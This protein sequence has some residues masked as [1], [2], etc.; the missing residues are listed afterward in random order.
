VIVIILLTYDRLTVARTTLESV[1]AN[2]RA[3]EPFWLH[4][5]DDGSSQEYRDELLEIAR[6]HYG[7]NVS[8]T[9]SNRAGYGGSYN[10]ATQIVH[11][12]ADLMLPL[13]DDWEL[14]RELDIGPIAAVLRDGLLNCIRM[15]YIGYTD[16]LRGIFRYHGGLHWLEL[17]PDSPEK[18]VFAGGPRLETVAFE[19]EVG[20][21]PERMEQGAT[22][23]KVIGRAKARR[24]V[25]WPV[26][27]IRPRGD[28][29]A[30]IGA[31]KAG[32]DAAG[33]A[34]PMQGVEA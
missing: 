14:I 18:H 33:S 31:V 9:N 20:P 23:L 17:D 11:K 4:I 7:D 34:A 15:G 21:W 29:F 2:L 26:D 19:R 32:T 5:A 25:A 27:L 24:G 28:A 6:A 3:E 8:I 16:E 30:H 12:V 1:A 13:E 22:E 10:K